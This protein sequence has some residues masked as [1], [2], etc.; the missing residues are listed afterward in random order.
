MGGIRA[1]AVLTEKKKSNLVHLKRLDQR[2]IHEKMGTSDRKINR[3]LFKGEKGLRFH[4]R[5]RGL[6]EHQVKEKKGKPDNPPKQQDSQLP[7]TAATAS[8]P[9]VAKHARSNWE[10]NL[11]YRL[12]GESQCT[13]R[14]R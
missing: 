11:A 5:R 10:A 14:L 8:P 1:A 6:C 9:G 7:I 4:G 2:P 12:V 3:S 13:Q